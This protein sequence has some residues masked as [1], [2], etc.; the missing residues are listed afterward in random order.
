[1][2]IC[3]YTHNAVIQSKDR[4]IYK[5]QARVLKAL[6]NETRLLIVDRLHRGECTVTELIDLVDLDQSTVSKHLAVLRNSGIV[7]DERQGNRVVYRLLTP[8]VM[9]FLSCA[10]DVLRERRARERF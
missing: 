3:D 6:A 2:A 5:T 8:C 9:N 7:E 1:M 10:A 4:N